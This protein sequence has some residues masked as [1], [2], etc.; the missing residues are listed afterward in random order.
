VNPPSTFQFAPVMYATPALLTST[1]NPPSF[2]TASFD[3]PGD[4]L[5]IGAIGLNRDDGAAGGVDPGGQFL[6]LDATRRAGH[7][8]SPS[9]ERLDVRYAVGCRG[10]V[11]AFRPV[12]SN[13]NTTKSCPPMVKSEDGDY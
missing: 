13:R 8:C 12:R 2:A 9:V 5:G 6:G 1:S 11:V 7:Q 3:R 4:L 10:H